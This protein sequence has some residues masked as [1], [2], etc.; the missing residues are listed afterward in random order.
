MINGINSGLQS[1]LQALQPKSDVQTPGSSAQATAASQN[2]EA[3][4]LSLQQTV[5]PKGQQAVEDYRALGQ[6][7]VLAATETSVAKTAEPQ[8]EAVKFRQQAFLATAALKHG[9]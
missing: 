1:A 5:Q 8:D 2:N 9:G 4:N 6:K 3:V 7:A